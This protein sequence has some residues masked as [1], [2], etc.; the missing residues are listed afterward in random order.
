MQEK[1]KFPQM[2][3]AP[4]AEVVAAIKAEKPAAVFM[5]HV[6]TATG[7]ILPDDY[8]TVGRT[9]SCLD[10]IHRGVFLG[11]GESC[12]WSRCHC[13]RWRHCCWQRVAGHEKSNCCCLYRD[14]N[15]CCR[16][17]LMF[18]WLHRK[19]AGLVLAVW[20]LP[21]WA[22]VRWRSPRPTQRPPRAFVAIWHNGSV[23][24]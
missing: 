11:G 8:I 9:R 16:L 6:E 3:P 1:E 21:A 4:I 22:R 2:A 17:A 12:A 10:C 13:C 5:P 20:A 14:M 18:M 23:G 7:I 15:I 24:W 19:R